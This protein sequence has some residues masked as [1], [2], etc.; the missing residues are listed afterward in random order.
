VTQPRRP[1]A[2]STWDDEDA[3]VLWQATA[4]ADA[5]VRDLA[6]GKNTDA[7]LE[8]LLGYLRE[9]VL[10]RI[11]DEDRHAL[12]VLRRAPG[13]HPELDELDQQHLQLRGD[14]EDLA[15][16]A[17]GH[18]A[19]EQQAGIMRRLVNHLEAHLAAEASLLHGNRH[20][21]SGNR[22]WLAASHWYPLIEG[23]VIEMDRL[24]ED[25]SEAA[26]LNRLTRLVAGEQVELRS[27]RDP[28]PIWLRLQQRAPGGYGWEAVQDPA[29][30]W[31]V[32]VGRRDTA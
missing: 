8:G 17:Q 18:S 2:A 32:T 10:A 28:H 15:A 21:V 11:S 16:A 7:D 4:R 3:Q 19:R 27:H 24:R 6:R 13:A 14:V 9:V 23:S 29:A 12:P 26:V 22:E 31:S 30:G 1:T 25:Q 20:T 5:L